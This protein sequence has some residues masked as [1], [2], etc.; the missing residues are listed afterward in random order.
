MGCVVPRL[1]QLNP[2]ECRLQALSWEWLA[3]RFGLDPKSEAADKHT[4]TQLI[5][6]WL[7]SADDAERQQMQ[8]GAV[9]RE[10]DSESARLAFLRNGCSYS[11]KNVQLR[12]LNA[13]LQRVDAENWCVSCP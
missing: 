12:A 6:P 4:L 7:I 10:H 8:D 1:L 2:P 9:T 3:A 13:A 11:R 5:F